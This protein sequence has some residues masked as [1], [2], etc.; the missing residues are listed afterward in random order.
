MFETKE[1]SIEIKRELGENGNIFFNA[2]I[3][4]VAE[5]IGYAEL[6]DG[7]GG[8]LVVKNVNVDPEYRGLGIGGKIIDA[9]TEFLKTENIEAVLHEKVEN[10]KQGAIYT[11]RGWTREAPG[12]S[13]H[14]INHL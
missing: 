1:N 2:Y 13:V 11:K 5:R 10:R 7:G 12:A 4:D 8:T 9:F 14:R 3:E 6:I